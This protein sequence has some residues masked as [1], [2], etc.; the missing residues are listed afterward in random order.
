MLPTLEDPLLLEAQP[1][2]ECC[3][4]AMIQEEKNDFLFLKILFPI[5]KVTI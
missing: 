4:E 1:I 3:L 5:Q 2:K